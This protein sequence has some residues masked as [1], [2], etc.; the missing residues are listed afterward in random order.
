MRSSCRFSLLDP[1]LVAGCEREMSWGRRDARGLL[2]RLSSHFSSPPPLTR[3]TSEDRARAPMGLEGR[4]FLLLWV[5]HDRFFPLRGVRAVY[6]IS[7]LRG[8][9]LIFWKG[10]YMVAEPSL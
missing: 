8:L 4:D 3:P 1:L 5:F 10:P 7:T 9:G 2:A 6:G